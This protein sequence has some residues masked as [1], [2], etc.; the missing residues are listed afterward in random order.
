MELCPPLFISVM[1]QRVLCQSKAISTD[2]RFTP[3]ENTTGVK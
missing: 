1:Y 2:G 3:I